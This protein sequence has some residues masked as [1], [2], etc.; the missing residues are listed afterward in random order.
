MWTDIDYMDHRRVFSLDEGNY[1]IEKMHRLIDYLHSRQQHYI[2]MV[3]P[4]V[5]DHDYP[6]YNR[7]MDLD[8]F[9]KSPDKSPFRALVWPVRLRF[10]L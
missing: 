6:A 8:I 1:P 2:V 7:G 3:D 5:A 10:W 4:A 9:V